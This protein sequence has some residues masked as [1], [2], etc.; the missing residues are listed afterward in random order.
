[1]RLSRRYLLLALGVFGI[2]LF[3]ALFVHD[4]FI[5]PFVGDVLVVVL[6]YCVV[7][8]VLPSPP[9]PTALGVFAFACAVE[10]AQY[11]QLVARLS[12]EHNV[13]LRTVIGTQADPLDLLAYALGTLSIVLVERFT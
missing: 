8:A 7:R 2:E 4:R 6:V 10:L 13:I 5:R 9:L 1:M 11:F 3:I 12:L